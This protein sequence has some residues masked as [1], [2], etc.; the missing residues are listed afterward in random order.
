[1]VCWI[2]GCTLA[3][4]RADGGK[5]KVRSGTA[6]ID[7]TILSDQVLE[8]RMRQGQVHVLRPAQGA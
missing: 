6:V 7:S 4:D 5:M 2:E 8:L 3:V 1:M